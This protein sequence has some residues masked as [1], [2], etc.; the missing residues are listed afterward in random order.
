MV[1]SMKI[2]AHEARAAL[3]AYINARARRIS[4]GT[5]SEPAG[6]SL[7]VAALQRQLHGLP[8]ERELLVK[9]LRARVRRGNY[10][11][12]S[13]EIVNALLGRLTADLLADE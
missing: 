13:D 12:S 1:E 11:V 5:L 9:G 8:D 3:D 10:H 7:P 6:L 4:K 2:S